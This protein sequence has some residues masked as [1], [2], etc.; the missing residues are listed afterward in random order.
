M[1][2]LIDHNVARLQ[3]AVNQSSLV[4]ML[5]GV[6]DLDHQGETL[7]GVQCM[8]F[9]IGQERLA[10]DELH[11]KVRL[12]AE[13]GIGGARFIDLRDAGVL[14]AAQR[15]RFMFEPPQ[16]LGR[17]VAGLDYFER[18]DAARLFLFGFIYR[19]HAPF[20]KQANNSIPAD[21][22]W[23]Q[24]LGSFHRSTSLGGSHRHGPRGNIECGRLEKT[25]LCLRLRQQRSHFLE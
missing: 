19:A 20:A 15:L 7:A 8:G 22:G 5:H 4:R 1:A 21:G 17:G 9:R 14:Q 12:P 3:I 16:V 13:G 2:R 23:K 11:R 10:A 18:H 24:T 6:T 25:S